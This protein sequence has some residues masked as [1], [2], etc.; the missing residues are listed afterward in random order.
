MKELI[1]GNFLVIWKNEEQK[2]SKLWIL[3][4]EGKE[5]MEIKV[6]GEN[7]TVKGVITG[8]PI[9]QRLNQL[10]VNIIGGFVIRMERVY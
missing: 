3:D 4:T 2:K 8:K 7:K 9:N 5:M 6:I 1:D 10:Q